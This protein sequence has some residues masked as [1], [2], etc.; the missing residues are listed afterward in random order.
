MEANGLRD[1][2]GP[3]KRHLQRGR[4][5]GGAEERGWLMKAMCRERE[6]ER[7]WTL[8][9]RHRA[10]TGAEDRARG[11]VREQQQ[12]GPGY[13]LGESKGVECSQARG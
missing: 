12:T 10:R 3:D 5:G 6:R 11:A 8:R 2:G 13:R 9:N 4:E 1:H 7:R